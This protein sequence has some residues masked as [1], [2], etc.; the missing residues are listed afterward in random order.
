[1]FRRVAPVRVVCVF[2]Y[3]SPDTAL[4]HDAFMSAEQPSTLP[5]PE[6]AFPFNGIHSVRLHCYFPLLKDSS[7]INVFAHLK[8]K[9]KKT[10]KRVLGI[11][12]GLSQSHLPRDIN[13]QEPVAS[14]KYGHNRHNRNKPKGAINLFSFNPW[15]NTFLLTV[16]KSKKIVL[17]HRVGFLGECNH[18]KAFTCRN[19]ALMIWLNSPITKLA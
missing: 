8:A 15:E 13:Q 18:I 10:T 5:A 11:P 7:S 3:P 2:T 17:P 4:S 16:L 1:M 6:R 14:W 19:Q 12:V 9:V